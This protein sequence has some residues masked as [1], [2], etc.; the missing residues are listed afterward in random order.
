[1]V[2]SRVEH[3]LLRGGAACHLN[4]AQFLVPF[5]FGTLAQG[6]EVEV[7]HFGLKVLPRAFQ[8]RGRDGR[9]HGNLA[10]AVGG[11]ADTRHDALAVLVA[12]KCCLLNL[13]LS[14]GLREPRS[15][16]HL[17]V[18][19]PSVGEAVALNGERVYHHDLRVHGG[20]PV[21]GL[22]QVEDDHALLAVCGD[23]VALYSTAWRGR[24]FH[25]D[26]VVGQPHLVIPGMC[27]LVGVAEARVHPKWGLG[28]A[29]G[30]RDGHE[31][32]VVEVA[33][34]CTREVGMAEAG[35][36]A[37]GIEIAGYAVPSRQSVVG[38]KL[39]HAKRS[40][41]PRVGVAGVVGSYE[42]VHFPRVVVG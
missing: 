39:H 33:R 2:E 6:V 13:H 9:G 32:D 3:G 42:G 1:M 11:E 26:V 18:A 16:P 20:V 17:L 41:R 8:S 15:E 14:H 35:Y 24:Q 21:H 28:L 5:A 23:G 19:R 34:A 27:R 10:R 12:F 25:V 30:Q 37:V 38:A 29:H 7:A 4:P 40:L 36:R 31:R 22:G